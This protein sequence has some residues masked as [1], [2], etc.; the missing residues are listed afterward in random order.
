MK[1]RR[2]QNVFLFWS[3]LIIIEGCSQPLAPEYRGLESVTITKI[4][5]N[6]S[7]VGAE[8]KLYNPNNFKLQLR[9][10]DVNISADDKFIG[11]CV[12][13]STI[14]IPRRDSFFI[15]VSVQVNIKSIL[16]NAVQL[17][18]KG[19][20]KINADGYVRLKKA[21]IGFNVPVHFEQ[22]Q[23]VDALLEQ[24]R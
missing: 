22:Y 16:S 17:L 1:K 6:N 13:D 23:G 4:G 10:A 15:P 20:V 11:H 18:L 5:L 8:V 12:I 14:D 21:G 24:I 2:W 3:V 7:R 19:Q 9:R